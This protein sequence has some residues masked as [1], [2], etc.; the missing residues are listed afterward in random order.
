MV[1]FT[2]NL[3][4]R[5]PIFDQDPWDEDVN[6]N[7]YVLD[8]AVGKFFGVANLVGVWLNNTAYSSGQTVIDST[9]GSMWTCNIGHTSATT[10]TSFSADRVA[11]P[12]YWTESVSTAQEYAAAAATSASAASVSATAASN[13]AVDAAN[14]AALTAGML[15]LTGGTMTGPLVLSADPLVALGAATKQYVDARVGGTGY[16]PLSG[17]TMTGV[18]TL[19][20]NPLSALDAAPKQYVDTFMPKSGGVFTGNISAPAV[21]ATNLYASSS[22]A[23]TTSTAQLASDASSTSLIF[24]GS[25]W[26]LQYNRSTGNLYY[27]RG[28]DGMVLTNT[29]PNGDFNAMG[30][31]TGAAISAGNNFTM[32]SNVNTSWIRFDPNNWTLQYQRASG[33]LSYFNGSGTELISIDGG[34]T[35]GVIGNINAAGSIGAGGNANINGNIVL[36][37]SIS[38]QGVSDFATFQTGSLRIHQYASSWYWKW[39]GSNGILTWMAG[40]AGYFWVFDNTTTISYNQLGPVGGHGVYQNLSDER[41][42]RDITPSDVG[43]P[44]ILK[45]K[46]IRFRR[47]NKDKL[48][49]GFSAQDVLKVIPEAVNTIKLYSEDEEPVERLTMGDTPVIAALVNAMKE[50]ATRVERLEGK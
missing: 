26:R 43:L 44:E 17:G 15:P 23:L 22:I 2:S 38:Y 1:D 21:S 42:K 36:G 30:T 41:V 31:I 48:E 16:L 45:L 32:F 33:R 10:P 9:D 40:G 49:I 35:I 47:D 46:P 18:L 12:S 19:S 28:S 5:V 20:G 37:G 34:G 11:H 29:A 7:W 50:L 14:S 8:A 25:L 4:L 24:D 3:H 13:S 39:D 6:A 27:V